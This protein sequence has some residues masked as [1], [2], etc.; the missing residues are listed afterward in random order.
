MVLNY[1]VESFG[2]FEFLRYSLLTN[3]QAAGSSPLLR[4]F[5]KECYFKFKCFTH[6][7][8]CIIIETRNK[9][10]LNVCRDITTAKRN[11]T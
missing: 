8:D 7:R 2:S 11:A 9:L 6:L 1:D 10:N 4:S 3:C 5:R